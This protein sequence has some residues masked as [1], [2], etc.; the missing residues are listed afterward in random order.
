MSVKNKDVWGLDGTF[1]TLEIDWS[2]GGVI[3]WTFAGDTDN[4]TDGS[5]LDDGGIGVM[6]PGDSNLYVDNFRE[7]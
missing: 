4:Y 7:V 2:A 3:T 1:R 5:P 6:G